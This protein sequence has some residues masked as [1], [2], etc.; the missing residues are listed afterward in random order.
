MQI[1]QAQGFTLIELMIVVAI[2]GI[3]ASIA[4]GFYGSYIISA[5]RTDA[6]SALTTTA[7][8]LE[9]CKALYGTYN[10]ASCNVSLPFNTVANLYTISGAPTASAFTLTATPMAGTPQANDSDCTTLTLANNG[11][12]SGSG[13]DI[14]KCW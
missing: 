2:V 1:K 5:N 12:Q 10:N 7:A 3:L 9:K 13:A 6:R 14:T 8:S 11:L 4:M